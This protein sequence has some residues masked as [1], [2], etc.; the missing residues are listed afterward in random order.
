MFRLAAFLLLAFPCT[1]VQAQ[2]REVERKYKIFFPKAECNKKAFAYALQGYNVLFRQG[3]LSNSRY[4]TIIDFTKP[5]NRKRLF[6]LDLDSRATII[7]S[8]ASHGIGSDPDSTTIPYR[9]S[10]RNGSKATSLGFYVT[11]DTYTNF[12]PLDSIGL[13]LF[14]L[15]KGYNDSAAVREIVLHYGATEY[16]GRVY[17]TDSGAAR[18]FGCPA[19]PLSTNRRVINLIKGGSCLFV[20]SAKDAEYPRKSTVLNVGIQSPIIQQGPP[21]NNCTC[22]LQPIQTKD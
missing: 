14:G 9:F 6:V 10:N 1:L 4:L 3:L 11:G 5:S 16:S 20:Y 21:P 2:K 7:S 17:V 15:D 8:I 13:C 12:R 18:S 19:L 22:N